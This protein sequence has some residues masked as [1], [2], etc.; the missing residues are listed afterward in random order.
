[1]VDVIFP[2]WESF[3]GLDGAGLLMVVAAA[4]M[5]DEKTGKEDAPVFP[6][7]AMFDVA[8]DLAEGPGGEGVGVELGESIIDQVV[9]DGQ[10]QFDREA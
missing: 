5:D 9:E 2:A 1:M 4:V 8:V 10:D 7:D 6:L 3:D